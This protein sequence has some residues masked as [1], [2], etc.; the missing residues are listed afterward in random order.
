M[1]SERDYMHERRV[2]LRWP[3]TIGILVLNVVV[4]GIQSA[5]D[6]FFPRFQFDH[7]FALSLDGLKSGFVW[8]LITFQFMHAG[9]LHIFLNSWAIFVFG[10]AVEQ[11]LGKRRMLILYFLSGVAGGGLQMLG[12]WLLPDLMD[13]VPVVGA[14]AGAF[15]LVAAFA[16]LFPNQMLYALLFFVIPIKLRASTLLWICIVVALVGIIFPYISSF[17]PAWSGIR[18][19]FENIG[20]AAH[21]GGIIVGYIFARQI[22]R[23]YQPPPVITRYSEFN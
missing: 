16:A 14:S 18:L 11:A 5:A 7:Y 10:R 15:G 13:N 20:H 9:F 12:T 23:Q 8:Q 1:L 21:L 3:A 2:G 4:F 6:R 17:V 22:V 19:L